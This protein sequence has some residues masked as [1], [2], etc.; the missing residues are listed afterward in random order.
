VTHELQG[1]PRGVLRLTCGV[2][3]GQLA[4]SDWI[5]AYLA[6]YPDVTADVDLTQRMV[7]LVHEGFDVAIRLGPL[8]DSTLTARRLGELHYGLFACPRYLARD[9]T[10]MTLDELKRHALLI[11]TSGSHRAGW[12]LRNGAHEVRI[13]GPARLSMNNSFAIRDAALRSLG[14][15]QLPLLVAADAIKRK[16]LVRV[17]P[18]C[19]PSPI[20]VHA[21]FPSRQYLTPKV[22]AFVDLAIER[23]PS[24]PE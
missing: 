20:P 15:A 6:A 24:V 9:G 10:P 22:R 2:E 13:D 17:L 8:E 5:D 3:F 7:D 23:F 4:V 16:R 1:A 21:V 19:A 18:E 11:Y 14:I 12:R